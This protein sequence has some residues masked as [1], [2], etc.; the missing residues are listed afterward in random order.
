MR[1][2]GY[3]YR[4]TAA[5]WERQRRFLKTGSLHPLRAWGHA[6]GGGDESGRGEGGRTAP[7]CSVHPPW[8]P[9]HCGAA[10]V[11]I[12]RQMQRRKGNAP[13]RGAVMTQPF[14]LLF[15]TSLSA[16]THTPGMP[17][18]AMGPELTVAAMWGLAPCSQHPTAAPPSWSF[19]GF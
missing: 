7:S 10:R 13:H 14:L 8:P 9:P 17:Y 1:G 12:S 15:S 3:F 4:L 11:P 6:G 18:A 16:H 2:I 19:S 5:V